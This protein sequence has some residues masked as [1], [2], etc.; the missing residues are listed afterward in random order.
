MGAP[1]SISGGAGRH[2]GR[3]RGALRAAVVPAR[4]GGR[5]DRRAPGTPDFFVP[6]PRHQARAGRLSRRTLLAGA[7][8]TAATAEVVAIP[9]VAHAL[10]T[11][12]CSPLLGP[13]RRVAVAAV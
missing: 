4:R 10:T 5:A 6:H 8:G 12:L 7:F 9:T 13:Y 3:R 11:T 1:A 2:A